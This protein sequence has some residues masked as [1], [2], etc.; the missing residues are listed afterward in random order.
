MIHPLPVVNLPNFE[1][2]CEGDDQITFSGGSPLGGTYYL[3]GDPATTLDPAVAFG[4]FEVEYIFT[5]DNGCV[6]Q[7]LEIIAVNPLPVLAFELDNACFDGVLQFTNT[8]FVPDGLIANVDWDFGILGGSTTYDPGDI[9]VIV[10]GTYDVFLEISSSDGCSSSLAQ[11]FDISPVPE[12]LFELD[13]GCEE[14]YFNFVDQSSVEEGEIIDWEWTIDGIGEY[15]TDTFG[16]NIDDWGVYG[17]TL[18]VT[19]AEGCENSLTL[20]LQVYP[21]PNVSF[22]NIG[23]CEGEVMAFYDE[24]EAIGSDL[25]SFTWN[26]G[27]STPEES[28]A[29]T[30]HVFNDG[31]TY[32]VELTVVTEFGCMNQII[33]PVDVAF[34]PDIQMSTSLAQF[35]AFG[36]TAFLD[37]STVQGGE[38]VASWAWWIDDELLSQDSEF[39]FVAN[40]PGNYDVELIVT[41]S[42]GCVDSLSAPGV[43]QVY[44]V[45]HSSF[46]HGPT[47]ADVFWPHVEFFDHSI[48]A[49]D[50]FY[51]FG[52]GT[53]GIEPNEDHVYPE[54]GDYWVIQTVTNEF[55]C[56]DTSMQEVIIHANPTVWVP[57]AFS[58]NFDGLNEEWSISL[59]GFDVES[60]QMLVFDRWGGVVFE[61]NDPY[62]SWNGHSA[63]NG[64]LLPEGVYNWAL[65]YQVGNDS[66]QGE[67]VGHVTVIR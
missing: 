44:P 13:P 32:D 36:E 63:R 37:L 64:E 22:F 62:F 56:T 7:D 30:D 21:I 57:N 20:P 16:M 66:S 28:G 6:S 15:G 60:F 39:V 48:G 12:A 27:D 54:I 58:P 51:D 29:Q 14:D 52:D 17:V 61:T 3:D 25:T 18:S 67:E 31:G 38:E 23:L 55:G 53:F 11:S 8:S 9:G 33:V 47:D 41:S 4:D 5:D 1:G 49:T 19:T 24:S 45:P 50:W 2:L 10:A 26:F 43:V 59:Y 35:C 42:A 65:K 40:E 46:S 34:T